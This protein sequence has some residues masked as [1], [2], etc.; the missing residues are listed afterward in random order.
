MNY[1]HRSK[2]KDFAKV[3]KSKLLQTGW[4]PAI[5]YDGNY[6]QIHKKGEEVKFFTSGGK[7]FYIDYIAEGLIKLNPN[8]NFTI[9]CEYIADTNGKLGSRTKCSTGHFRSQFS[10]G[11][12]SNAIQGKTKFKVF[13][14]LV[15]E[16]KGNTDNILKN[17]MFK[18]KIFYLKQI[19]LCEG[20]SLAGYYDKPFNLNNIDYKS[21]VKEGYEG[22]FIFHETHIDTPVERDRRVNTAIK[23]KSRPTADLLCI[24]VEAGTGKYV[25]MIGSLV[26]KDSLGRIVKVGSGL[27]DE[28]RNL[29]I[30]DYYLGKVIEIEYEQILDTYIQPIFKCVRKEKTEMDID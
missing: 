25:E 19:K 20:L 9:E 18:D 12:P 23:L 24:D 13:N 17:K 30:T 16:H 2:G 3:P 1:I 4:Y 8:I 27:S 14:V 10:K 11:L 21:L 28:Q 22:L 26:L 29:D 6:I 15:F 5:K 7:E